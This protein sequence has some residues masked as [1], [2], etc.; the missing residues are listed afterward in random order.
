MRIRIT[1]G[2]GWYEQ[3]EGEVYEVLRTRTNRRGKKEYT[4][5]QSAG[6]DGYVDEDDCEIV[7]EQAEGHQSTE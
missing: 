7:E 6:G 4:V 2:E 5:W 1:N 3:M